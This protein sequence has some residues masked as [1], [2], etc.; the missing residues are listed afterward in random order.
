[1][2]LIHHGIYATADAQ[3][4]VV[5]VVVMVSIRSLTI[6]ENVQKSTFGT[7]FAISLDVESAIIEGLPLRIQIE[8]YLY[9]VSTLG[10][11]SLD[12]MLE[13]ACIT[14]LTLPKRIEATWNV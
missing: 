11:H 3:V 10:V 13:C 2:I 12:G 8:L 1:M 14:C 9:K 5:I 4:V 7:E 6:G